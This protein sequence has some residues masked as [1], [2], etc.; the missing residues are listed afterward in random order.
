MAGCDSPNSVTDITDT[1]DTDHKTN[2]RVG[3][4]A[5]KP[6]WYAFIALVL[7]ELATNA[8]IPP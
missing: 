5:V 8:K 6:F 2:Y 1:K 7:L 4:R 3:G